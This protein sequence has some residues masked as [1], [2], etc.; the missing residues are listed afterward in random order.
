MYAR[1]KNYCSIVPFY[2]KSKKLCLVG[3]GM[4]GENQ[5]IF[6]T[7]TVPLVIDFA[8]QQYHDS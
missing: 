1:Y 8:L 2:K 7:R 3:G 5:Y 4:G 6:I